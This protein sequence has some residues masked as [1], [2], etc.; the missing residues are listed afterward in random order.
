MEDPSTDLNVS[1]NVWGDEVSKTELLTNGIVFFRFVSCGKVT[2]KLNYY[3]IYN[4]HCM[5]AFYFIT[6]Y[7][8]SHRNTCLRNNQAFR[9]GSTM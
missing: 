3:Y 6:D 9:F 2:I 5:F 4:F 7:M 1:Y 8:I